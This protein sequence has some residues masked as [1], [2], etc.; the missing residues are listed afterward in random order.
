MLDFSVPDGS[1]LHI[2][3]RIKISMWRVLLY[4]VSREK[5]GITKSDY[6]S[7][8]SFG[9]RFVAA[10][11]QS[12][13]VEGSRKAKTADLVLNPSDLIA[14][15]S[16]MIDITPTGCLYH[17][18]RVALVAEHL[19][20]IIAPEDAADTFYAGLL[21]DVGTVG[22]TKHITQYPSLQ[23]QLDDPLIKTHPRRGAALLDWLP[24]LSVSAK[25]VRSHHEWWDGRG[26]PD[27]KV[28]LEIPQG[29]QI[30]RIVD[31]V[32]VAGGFTS[33]ANLV[34][35]LKLLVKFTG[36]AW[37]KDMWV[38]LLQSIQDAE[39]Y[40]KIMDTTGLQGL[41]SDRLAK[42]K[43]PDELNN[44]EGIERV[45]HVFAALVDAKD[46]ST[47][48][49]SLRT[50]RLARELA[51]HMKLSEADVRTAYHAGLVH[52]CG[53]LGVPTLILKRSGRL[54]EEEMNLVRKHAQMTTRV[55]SCIPSSPDM[56]TLGEIAGHDHERYDGAGYPDRMSGE[57]IHIISRILSV[58]DAFDAMTAATSYKHLLSPRFAVIRLQQAAGSQ[59]DPKVVDAMTSAV[60]SGL[61]DEDQPAAA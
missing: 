44:D 5:Y 41:V 3:R 53:R 60:E 54:N 22:A 2:A 17:S 24:G 58:A 33:S 14:A 21:M 30:L 37:S 47:S 46:P 10:K 1:L 61:L 9:A 57:N 52:D 28:G 18:W 35:C 27:A 50:A 55:L 51:R 12:G 29:S 38:G 45:L 34:E 43:L 32:E 25:L 36:H 15:A 26:Y 20:S 7:S 59:F 4:L 6:N 8:F 16:Y 13:Q 40:K 11:K 56:V 42:H 48:G 19:A 49:H 39:F 31:T 23:K